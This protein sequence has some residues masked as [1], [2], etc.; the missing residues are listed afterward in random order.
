ME[1]LEIL[2]VV[3][4]PRTTYGPEGRAKAVAGYV[5][6]RQ[7]KRKPWL[8]HIM[9]RD[10]TFLLGYLSPSPFCTKFPHETWVFKEKGGEQ[11][12]MLSVYEVYSVDLIG[13]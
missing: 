5:Q 7:L 10:G 13:L 9:L 12:L 3:E 6:I 11:V 4:E 2:T 8:F 1:N